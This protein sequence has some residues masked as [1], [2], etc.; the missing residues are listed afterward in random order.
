MSLETFKSKFDKAPEGKSDTELFQDAYFK[1]EVLLSG[2]KYCIIKPGERLVPRDAK[3]IDIEYL[4][5]SCFITDI[6]VAKRVAPTSSAPLW[7]H[8]LL[9]QSGPY[10]IDTLKKSFAVYRQYGHRIDR[11]V[12]DANRALY[13]EH[14]YPLLEEE[15]YRKKA[16]ALEEQQIMAGKKREDTLGPYHWKYEPTY[17]DF[18]RTLEAAKAGTL[19]P[20]FSAKKRGTA[21][22]KKLALT[23]TEDELVLLYSYAVVNGFTNVLEELLGKVASKWKSVDDFGGDPIAYSSALCQ[24]VVDH[25]DDPGFPITTKM[26]N[27]YQMARDVILTFFN[28][29]M[30]A[31]DQIRSIENDPSAFDLSD[32]IQKSIEPA[33]QRPRGKPGRKAKEA[34]SDS[35]ASEPSTKASAK[36]KKTAEK[37][38]ETEAP[39]A[40]EKPKGPEAPK[41]T[42][43][44]KEPEAPK[45]AEKPKA[46]KAAEKPKEPEAPKT[47]EKPKAPKAA[48]KPKEPEAPKVAEKPK[49][50]EKPAEVPKVVETVIET[51]KPEPKK[52]APP[53]KKAPAAAE[54]IPDSA[55]M[56]PPMAVTA[57]ITPTL[58]TPMEID[59]MPDNRKRDREESDES[60]KR[61]RIELVQAQEDF[62]MNMM[63]NATD[64]VRKAF[65]LMKRTLQAAD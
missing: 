44:P 25:L 21:P 64:L 49:E 59:A 58:P 13:R 22:T 45:A 15:F 57:M 23:V 16:Q 2:E 52:R 32:K 28:I 30:K 4:T 55:P 50:V 27:D 14:V 19:V 41:V 31:V 3:S 35:D 48:E 37:P 38:K 63:A 53:K 1:K 10:V 56:V 46:P 40:A 61:R 17:T 24:H 5:N 9:T 51:A 6:F 29:K 60:A 54:P 47:A 7:R 39:Q 34:D 11:I 65:D 36:G 42:E 26:F 12:A 18:R 33:A 62:A 20:E 43:K 8:Y